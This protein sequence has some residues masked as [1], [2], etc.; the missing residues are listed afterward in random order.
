MKSTPKPTPTAKTDLTKL[1][2]LTQ[3][4]FKRSKLTLLLFVTLVTAG[5]YVYTSTIKKE[6]FPPVQFPV[7][8]VSGQYF[9]DDASQVDQRISQPLNNIVESLGGVES[10]QSV[11]GA[12]FFRLVVF[13]EEGVSAPEGTRQ[14]EA[15]V[16]RDA[17][18]P[19]QATVSYQPIEP[20]KFLNEYDLLLSVYARDNQSPRELEAVGQYVA[21]ELKNQEFVMETEVQPL[22]SQAINP[23]DGRQIERQ[24][25]FSRIGVQENGSLQFYPA[26][27]VS[28]N[29]PEA[30]DV[31]RLSS[32]VQDGI[33]Q[34]DLSQF[35]GQF[36]VQ[37]S[38][39]F[40][41]L[42][43][44]QI[45]SLESNLMTGLIAVSIVSLLLISWR[46]SLIT[47]LFMVAVMATVVLILW[48]VGYTLNTITLF[49]LVLSLGLFVDDATIVV[50]AIDASRSK[51]RKKREVVLHAIR[52]VAAAS[53]SGT[54]T[55][56]LVFLPLTFVSGILGE[57]IRLLPITVIISLLTSLLLSLTL[58]PVLSRYIL[59]SK[60]P[61][62]FLARYN[63]IAWLEKSLGERI[64]KL[65]LL[66]TSKAKLAY[67]VAAI[68]IGISVLFIV[69]AGYFA[70]KLSFNIFPP[71][72]DSEQIAY[73]ITFAPQTTI[74]QAQAQADVVNAIV[75]EEAGEHIER[76]VYGRTSQP[77]ERSADALVE[78]TPIDQR[79]TTSQ[80][81]LDR[82]QLAV[83]E[84]ALANQIGISFVQID[85]GPPAE[86]FP[87]KMQIYEEDITTTATALA[88]AV[89]EQLDSSQV[90]LAN[91]ELHTITEVRLQNAET[92]SR[93]GG[94]RFIELQAAF[95]GNDTSALVEATQDRVESFLTDE[96]L[97]TYGIER[98]AV[99]FDFGQESENADSFASLSVA[100]PVAL[101]LMYLLLAIQF[102]SIAQPLLIFIAIP[103]SLFG[104]FAGLYYTD[105][106][107]SFFVQVGLI[108]LIGIAVNN[109]IMLTDYANQELKAG[110]N[111]YQAISEATKLRFRPLLATSIT[112]VVALI[113]LA[114]TD[115]F[116]E[117]LA[118][119]IIFGLLSSTFLVIIAFPYYYLI[120]EYL[121]HKS[122]VKL[123]ILWLLGLG[124]GI[125]LIGLDSVVIAFIGLYSIL[126]YFL[127][128]FWSR[129]VR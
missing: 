129:A 83:A 42:V 115:P 87:F 45:G 81:L 44:S 7:A 36:E 94:R 31:L 89:S 105:N 100:F 29:G 17:S 28:I 92:I 23:A 20:V 33:D 18:L 113:P 110:K 120:F 98:E 47:A 46:A 38:A 50:E 122:S 32:S 90:E 111:R 77:T 109:S 3:V 52:R 127:K 85:A 128:G 34:L 101:L 30:I 97:E 67:G 49:G 16:T 63:P 93:Q 74:E 96:F 73:S 104:V 125:W 121:R 61:F 40:A 106:P 25:S 19:E 55:T 13:F 76:I 68:S 107:F 108:G 51:K 27:T 57:F 88:S 58:I 65:P 70:S 75:A 37:R 54:L 60:Q 14:I 4:F 99:S 114:L 66:F 2:K 79:D 9:V 43:S 12:N 10:V 118:L 103:F 86:Q 39:D 119:T 48:L 126:T 71:T 112:T 91:G 95:S 80:E 24:T 11:A 62:T 15:A 26:V 5:A 82:L 78:L 35:D 102:R 84:S 8:I 53:M 72:K 116:W 64:S 21:D 124:I 1:Q 41:D 56:V 59:L 69:G 117:P 6:G 123:V 22:L